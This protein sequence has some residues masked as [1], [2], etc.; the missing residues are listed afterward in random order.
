MDSVTS[1]SGTNYYELDA[2]I[3]LRKRL[4]DNLHHLWRQ[5]LLPV[6]VALEAQ[7][8]RLKFPLSGF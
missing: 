5:P 4:V 3:S 2:D 1:L 7:P 8:T 6:I